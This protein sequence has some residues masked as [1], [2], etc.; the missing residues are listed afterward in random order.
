MASR[1][2]F[3][4]LGIMA[5]LLTLTH[6]SI[7]IAAGEFS[8]KLLFVYG[9]IVYMLFAITYLLPQLEKQDERMKFIKQKTMQYSMIAVLFYI[10]LL[11]VNM[12]GE[13]V[14]LAA[15]EMLSLLMSMSIVTIW[16]I[17]IFMAKTN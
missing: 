6:L 5:F 11:T 13:F 17:W 4:I 3:L 2:T 7:L 15:G 10:V 9:A 8:L 1:K 12:T 14:P 16:S